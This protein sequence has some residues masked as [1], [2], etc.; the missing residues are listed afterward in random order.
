MP[1]LCLLLKINGGCFPGIINF[2]WV[3]ER[4]RHSGLTFQ[5][6]SHR[7]GLIFLFLSRLHGVKIYSLKILS[8]TPSTRGSWQTVVGQHFIG[9]GLPSL[10][11]G[12]NWPVWC[13][14]SSCQECKPGKSLWKSWVAKDIRVPLSALL[15][16]SRGK[17]SSMFGTSLAA[18]VCRVVDENHNCLKGGLLLD[19]MSGFTPLGGLSTSVCLPSVELILF[20]S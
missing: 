9:W 13:D 19:F 8:Y 20:H 3:F 10:R 1:T 6:A 2:L 11:A 16:W 4:P 12:S 14:D 5:L 15:M 7:K 18:G 17:Q